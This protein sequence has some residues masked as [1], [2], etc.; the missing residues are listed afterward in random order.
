MAMNW[1]ERKALAHFQIRLGPMRVGPH[2]LLQP[3]RRRAQADAERRHHSRRSRQVRLLDRA[4]DRT[5]RVVH[6]LHGDSVRPVAG[7]Q[8]HE[9]RHP[10]HA[11]RVVAGRARHRDRGMGVELALSADWRAALERADGFLRSGHGTGGRLG[12]PDDQHER[13]R[14]RH[15]EHDRNRAGAAAAGH[16]VP[17][18][19]LS[20]RA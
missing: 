20:A 1:L 16:L 17:L 10:L 7:R 4:A 12:D 19:V 9:H 6:G 5:A 14:H 11:R 15:A 13:H 18:Q 3:I 2:G 8:R